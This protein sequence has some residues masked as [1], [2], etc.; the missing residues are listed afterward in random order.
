[1]AAGVEARG[2]LRGAR[3]RPAR[4]RAARGARVRV[5]LGQRLALRGRRAAERV[6]SAAPSRRVATGGARSAGRRAAAGRG[7]RDAEVGGGELDGAFEQ[8]GA[9]RA[10]G[11]ARRR[12]PT[13]RAACRARRARARA[14]SAPGRGPSREPRVAS[15]RATPARVRPAASASRRYAPGKRY[16]APCSRSVLTSSPIVWRCTPS[17]AGEP[18]LAAEVDQHLVA[19]RRHALEELVER[20][21]R[22][23]LVEPHPRLQREHERERVRRHRRAGRAYPDGTARCERT[24]PPRWA[25]P[26][27][28]TPPLASSSSRS[29]TASR[30]RSACSSSTSVRA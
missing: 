23:E 29:S 7:E 6:G 10:A 21:R 3:P 2:D 16:A 19:P 4:R 30:S 14:R 13:A 27:G 15:A 1:M 20:L 5:G 18:E 11:R 17:A 22:V 28:R 12:A 9:G 8:V 26:P 24:C 25:P